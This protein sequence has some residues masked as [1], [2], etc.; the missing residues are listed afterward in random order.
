MDKLLPVVPAAAEPLIDQECPA[1]AGVPGLLF[2]TLA[3]ITAVASLTGLVSGLILASEISHRE[4]DRLIA[5]I[6]S[7]AKVYSNELWNAIYREDEG[8]GRA[9]ARGLLLDPSIT[10]VEIRRLPGQSWIDISHAKEA[11]DS[12]RS[13]DKM[14]T[15]FGW[16]ISYVSDRDRPWVVAHSLTLDPVAN[17]KAEVVLSANRDIALSEI[18]RMVTETLLLV[19]VHVAAVLMTVALVVALVVVRPIQAISRALHRAQQNKTLDVLPIPRGHGNTEIG[20]LVS[21]VNALVARLISSLEQERGMREIHDNDRRRYQSLVDNAASGIFLC[22]VDGRLVSWNAAYE[23]LLGD[24]REGCRQARSLFDEPWDS[25]EAVRHAFSMG[26]GLPVGQSL[27]EDFELSTVRGD[28]AWVNMQLLKVDAQ[29]FQGML[30]DVTDRKREEISAQRLAFSDPLTGLHRREGLVQSLVN[31][32]AYLRNFALMVMHIEGIRSLGEVAGYKAADVLVTMIADRLRDIEPNKNYLARIGRSHFAMILRNNDGLSETFLSQAKDV[33]DSLANPYFVV[34]DH[35]A[36]LHSIKVNAGVGCYPEHG[37]SIQALLVAAE[38]ALGSTRQVSGGHATQIA[39]YHPEITQQIVS[40][41]QFENDL[42][43]AVQSKDLQVHFQPIVDLATGTMVGA[44]TLIRW[45]HPDRGMVPPDLFIP[46]AE[47]NDL[48]GEIGDFVLEEA[49]RWVSQW[50]QKGID[51]YVSVNVSGKQIPDGLPPERVFSVLQEYELPPSALV[52]EITEG[53]VMANVRITKNW[54]DAIRAYGVRV[55]LDD[56]GTGYSALSYLK[57]Y[58][59]D[60]VKIDK[61]FVQE[62]QFNRSDLALVEAIITMATRLGM[63][64][65]AEGIEEPVHVALLSQ[66]GCTLGQGY[67]FSKPVSPDEVERFAIRNQKSDSANSMA[68]RKRA[69]FRVI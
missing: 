44:E 35:E 15:L 27:S 12:A 29:L 50:R 55:Y 53:V 51:A 36:K 20:R 58:H 5:H 9:L 47:E 68:D 43:E 67:F 3:W 45:A 28:Q 16:V 26:L 34:A 18:N 13:L 66:M 63:Q 22:D 62:M 6:D 21:D 46:I 11:D 69:N 8:H 42:R 57:R 40:Q 38:I 49:C 59:F 60:C 25:V 32:C 4:Y 33:V 19:I 37:S 39:I 1:A 17:T 61:S 41:K 48:I 54:L 31:D 30:S 56:F 23:A 64:V 52:L 10:R 2:R 7:L 65:V 14:K 24:T